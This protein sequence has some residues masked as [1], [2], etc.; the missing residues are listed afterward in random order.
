[1][2]FSEAFVHCLT[3]AGTVPSAFIMKVEGSSIHSLS[4]P[5]LTNLISNVKLQIPSHLSG[6]ELN[7]VRS[8]ELMR[9]QASNSVFPSSSSHHIGEVRKFVTIHIPPTHFDEPQQQ[10]NV[11]RVDGMPKKHIN[12]IFV[13]LPSLLSSKKTEV[14][15]PD[16]P[17]YK[18]IVYVLLKK[19]DPSNNIR[20][21]RPEPIQPTKPEVYFIQYKTPT[22]SS[23]EKTENN[24]IDYPSQPESH[25]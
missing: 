12:I 23:S 20:I 18:N 24:L 19:Q 22:P 15:L 2:S 17:Q 21:V 14:I 6:R 4:S 25:R 8:S 5:L 3:N 1:M 11:I 16:P 13:K 9:S 7:V 10:S